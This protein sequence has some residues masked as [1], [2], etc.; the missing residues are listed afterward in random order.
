M[1]V[2]VFS[3]CGT[4]SQNSY[5]IDLEIWGLFDDSSAY[6]VAIENYKKINPY[7]GEI[8]YKKFTQET[9]K[10]DLLDAIAAGQ[11]PDIF[12]INNA[13]LPSFENKLTPVTSAITNEQEMRNNFL[14]V[15]F[16]DFMSNGQMYGVP[17]SVD[18]LAL[19]YN[20]DLF[21][22]IGIS[23]PPKTWHELDEDVKKITQINGTGDIIQSGIAMGTAKNINRAS[24]IF[25]MLMMQNGIEMPKNKTQKASFDQGTIASNGQT[26]QVGAQTLDYY[27]K[28]ATITLPPNNIPNPYYTWNFRMHN[29]IDAFV[30]GSTAMMFNYSWQIATI[31]S[32]NSKL[33]FAITPVPQISATKPVNV[34]NYWAYVVARNKMDS[35]VGANGQIQTTP[36]SQ[37]KND[38]RV[39]EAWEFLK[40]LTMKNNGSVHLVNAITKKSADFPMAYDPALEYLKKTQKPA[41]RLDIIEMQKTDPLL[42]SFATGNLIAKSW[43]RLNP[44]SAQSVLDET[45]DSVVKGDVS[46][47]EALKLAATRIT[48]LNGTQR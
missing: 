10:Q 5:K 28:F 19:Y 39:H 23:L 44:D 27:R 43:Y 41:A 2:L 32:Q 46:I 20:K 47:N 6:T 35:A 11:G 3:G 16:D 4:S 33:N 36:M 18:S 31:K 26:V 17:L 9:Y 42:S 14:D 13:W 38:A 30:E 29:S 25:V 34:A 8:K 40:Y 22:A 1:A 48:V 24:D 21:N 15:V 45:I 7:V 37:I 12:L